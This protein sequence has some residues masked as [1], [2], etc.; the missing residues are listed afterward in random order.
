[1]PL[2]DWQFWV[3]TG[4]AVGALFFVV[5]RTLPRRRQARRGKRVSLTINQSSIQKKKNIHRGDAEAAEKM[6]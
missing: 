1:M 4:L 5:R 2:G 3:V 6:N